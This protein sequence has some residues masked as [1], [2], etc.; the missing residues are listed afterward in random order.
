[1]G[2]K[3][4][5]KYRHGVAHGFKAT[6]DECGKILRST[7]GCNRAGLAYAEVAAKEEYERHKKNCTARYQPEKE[8]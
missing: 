8:K 2:L 6:C 3:I 4:Q 5:Y 1:M 7:R